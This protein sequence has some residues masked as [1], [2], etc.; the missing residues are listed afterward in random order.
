M[1]KTAQANKYP[2]EKAAGMLKAIAHPVRLGILTFL[3]DGEKNVTEIQEAM[4][5]KQSITSQQL[6]AMAGKGVLRRRK[7]A[8]KVYYSIGKRDVLKILTCMK[9]CCN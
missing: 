6:M 3:K 8:N 1:K 9:D 4:D 2:Y 7:K 5:A